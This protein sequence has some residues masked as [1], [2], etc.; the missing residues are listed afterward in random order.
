MTTSDTTKTQI[1]DSLKKAIKQFEECAV[2]HRN[3]GAKDTEPDSVF[4]RLLLNAFAG[5]APTPPRRATGWELYTTMEES[6]AAAEE[7]FE[8]SLEVV[9]VIESCAIR[10]VQALREYLNDYCW[11]YT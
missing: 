8:A 11:R 5:N 3:V 2:K 7:L 6:H 9:R 10:D 4:Q 1:V